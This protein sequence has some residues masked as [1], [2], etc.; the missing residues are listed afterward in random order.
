MISPLLANIYLHYALD[1]WAARWRRREARGD[2]VIVRYADDAVFG[3]ESETDARRF[4]EAMR[5]RLATFA[6]ALHPDKTRLIA[7][8]RRAAANRARGG[9]G[10]ASTGSAGDL[11]FPRLHLLCGQS[12]KGGFLLKRKSRRDRVRAEFAGNQGRAARSSCTSRRLDRANGSAGWSRAGSTTMPRPQ[13]R[14]AL[15]AFRFHVVDLCRRTLRRRGQKDRTTW[16]RIEALAD[17]RLPTQKN[18]PPVAPEPLR[19]QTPELAAVCG[20]PARTV[21]CGGRSAMSVPTAIM[22]ERRE[23]NARAARG[24]AAVASRSPARRRRRMLACLPRFP[25]PR[26]LFADET[27]LSTEFGFTKAFVAN[28]R[29]MVI[30][31][32]VAG[33]EEGSRDPPSF[34]RMKRARDEPGGMKLISSRSS[35]AGCSSG[36]AN[37]PVF[38]ISDLLGFPWIL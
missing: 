20:N 13:T 1:L 35:A 23:K 17:E 19:R 32:G 26:G 24:L 31:Q 5:E 16:R 18:P 12:R 30:R 7:F 36:F 28:R 9:L 21:L 34:D 37:L 14:A 6:L 8:G 27:N 25:A 4:L 33:K 22:G 38:K 10:K 15:G 29:K 11:Q 3:F 2:M